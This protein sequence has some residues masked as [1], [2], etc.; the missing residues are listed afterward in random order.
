MAQQPP[1]SPGVL[2]TLASRPHLDTPHSAGFLSSSDQLDARSNNI[3]HSQETDIH[4]PGGI[5]T[6]NP[7]K[8]AGADPYL[9]RAA[10]G[11]GFGEYTCY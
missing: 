9:D 6:H 3:Q 1:V 2:I 7:S 10:T 5:R 11:I 4:V 8:R